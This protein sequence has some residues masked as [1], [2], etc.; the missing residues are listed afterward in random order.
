MDESQTRN[1][2]DVCHRCLEPVPPKAARCPRCGEPIHKSSNI[3]R[4]LAV[5]GLL[6][7]LVVAAVAFRLMQTSGARPST[8]ADQQQ[9]RPGDPDKPPPPEKKPALGQ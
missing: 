3:R 4:I 8:D 7:F 9:Q 2:V 1:R 5:F 6:M